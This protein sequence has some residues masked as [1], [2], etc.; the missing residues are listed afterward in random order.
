MPF[1]GGQA[2]FARDGD[3]GE[4][5]FLQHQDG[6]RQTSPDDP[7]TAEWS[8]VDHYW[9]GRGGVDGLDGVRSVTASPE[10]RHIYVAGSWDNA[11]AVF[12]R[13]AVTGLLAFVEVIRSGESGVGGLYGA[14]S[15]SVSPDGR[16]VYATG[17]YDDAVV[18]FA[19]DA[20]TGLLSFLQVF[21]DGEDSVNGLD[22]VPDQRASRRSSSVGCRYGGG[23][24]S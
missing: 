15:V 6:W 1:F 12:A 9:N 19:R 17:A 4:L 16:H 14:S 8:F 3:S 18:V 5:T 13:D 24:E 7:A 21:R 20:Q 11:V 23:T 2:V 10:G 22:G